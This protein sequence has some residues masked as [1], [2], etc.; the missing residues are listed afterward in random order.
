VLIDC[1]V[2]NFVCP[3]EHSS[4]H[5]I[6]PEELSP[7]HRCYFF[8]ISFNIIL[9]LLLGLRNG[10]FPSFFPTEGFYCVSQSPIPHTCPD[11]LTNLIGYLNFSSVLLLPV[12]KV[13][14]FF[15]APCSQTPSICMRDQIPHPYKRNTIIFSYI[16]IFR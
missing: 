14:A 13:Q 12:S 1:Q 9:L 2:T 11:N 4:S 5:Y 16:S 3:Q 7:H 8:N 10:P 15:F 6:E